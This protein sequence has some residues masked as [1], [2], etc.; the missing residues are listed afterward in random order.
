MIER[1]SLQAEIYDVMEHF[2]VNKVLQG[3]SL[4]YNVSP[5]QLVTVIMNDR[6]EQRV[7]NEARWGLFPFWAK[8]AI[9][10]TNADITRKSFLL[11]MVKRN[12]C[13]IPCTGFYG[14]KH[15]GAE[16]QPRAMHIVVPG[17]PL[18]GVAAIFD[19]FRNAR[20]QEYRAFSL[21]TSSTS[22]TMSTWQPTLPVVLDAEG[23]EQ[24][25][26]PKIRDFNTLN[27]Y[28]NELESY[29]LRAYPVTNA[30]HDDQYESPDCVRELSIDYA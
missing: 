19:C 28:L 23:I 6:H 29:Q 30:I 7:V 4:R 14:S 13:V 3:H 20:G 17:K 25:L 1:F 21:L 9:N 27:P 2:K 24:W 5:T 8:D 15:V 10:T 16:K 12:R 18:F 11:E 22:G 26:N